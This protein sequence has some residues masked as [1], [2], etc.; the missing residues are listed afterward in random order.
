MIINR[1]RDLEHVFR[2]MV[3][4]GDVA[5]LSAGA[6]KT[7][8]VIRAHADTDLAYDSPSM[9]T[10]VRQT[11]LSESQ[12]NDCLSELVGAGYLTAGAPAHG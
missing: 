2:A 3:E 7:Y 10:I 5:R 4:S 11:G 8:L 12:V 9:Q 1:E 6:V